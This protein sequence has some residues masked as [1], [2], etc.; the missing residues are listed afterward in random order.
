MTRDEFWAAIAEAGW[1]TKTTDHNVVKLQWMKQGK[2]WCNQ[3]EK[4]FDAVVL[5]LEEKNSFGRGS[6]SS[7]DCFNH[8]IGLGQKEFE[9]NCKEHWRLDK[10]Y[11]EGDY[12][13]S[14]TYCFPYET[15]WT[16][17]TPKKM[18]EW[19]KRIIEEINQLRKKLKHW[20]LEQKIASV[21][22][23]LNHLEENLEHAV[24]ENWVDFMQT[25]VKSKKLLKAINKKG[26]EFFSDWDVGHLSFLN[27]T[28]CHNLYHNMHRMLAM[29]EAGIV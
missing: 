10:R 11:E 5:E 20:D 6:D 23:W 18:A 12:A 9:L 26:K 4:H 8:V 7:N 22:T 14:F 21:M 16:D 2:K 15:D 27:E 25:E 24:N 3:L 13:E 19:A 1:G 28:Y 29:Q 17:Y